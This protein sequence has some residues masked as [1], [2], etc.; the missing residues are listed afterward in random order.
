MKTSKKFRIFSLLCAV[1]M[2]FAMVPAASAYTGVSAWAEAPVAE[3]KGLGLIPSRM[4]DRDL[5][6]AITREE[7]CY[8]AVQAY[9]VYN[10]ALPTLTNSEPFTDTQD[11][12]IAMAYQLGFAKGYEDGTFQPNRN[13]TR[14]EFFCLTYRFLQSTGCTLKDPADLSSF[15]DSGDVAAWAQEATRALVALEIVKGNGDAT[16]TPLGEATC[17]VALVLFY[18]GYTYANAQRH[19]LLEK[20]AGFSQWA[21]PSIQR[22]D[23]LELIPATLL[24]TD[25]RKS[26]TRGDMCKIAMMAYKKANPEF[27]PID[28]GESPFTDTDDPDYIAAWALSIVSGFPE[29]DGTYTFRPNDYLTR[30][31]FFKITVSCLNSLGLLTKDSVDVELTNYPDGGELQAYA[32]APARL[33]ISLG[34]VNGDADGHLSP[35]RNASAEEAV[36]MFLR[37][38]DFILNYEERWNRDY[39]EDEPSVAQDIVD[40]ALKYVGWRYIWGGKSPSD[41]GFDCTGLLY[42]VYGQ[43]GYKLYR[44]SPWEN[45]TQVDVNEMKPGDVM[46]FSST[47]SWNNV[48]HVA[49]YV[50][51]GQYVHAAN[52]SRGVVVDTISWNAGSYCSRCFLGAF[53]IIWE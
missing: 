18:R 40:L 21:E 37:A 36:V 25:L 41:G 2:L 13:M 35:T 14:Q 17:E 29:S 30:E 32:Q 4:E 43:Y 26:I 7:M 44:T 33:L 11:E 22:M 45:G 16:L 5:R 52:P 20:Y 3:M 1:A 38:Y 51:G 23:E 46:V 6:T 53:R 27:Q 12:T 28:V 49:M 10:G 19:P 24:G 9:Q 47:G 34:I 15:V 50:G 42:Y 31:Q 8:V 48:T 39:P